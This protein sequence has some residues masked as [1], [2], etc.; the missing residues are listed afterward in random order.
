MRK[1]SLDLEK[2]NVQSFDTTAA[3]RSTRGT[4]RGHDDPTHGGPNCGD[5]SIADACV[6]GLCTFDCPATTVC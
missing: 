4:V 3:A 2:L 6:T 5:T 1:L